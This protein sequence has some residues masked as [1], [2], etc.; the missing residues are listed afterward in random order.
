[1][2]QKKYGNGKGFLFVLPHLAGVLCFYFFPF[3]DVLRRSFVQASGGGFVGLANYRQVLT[4][5]AFLLAASN[6]AR[7]DIV[8]LPLLL[9][10]ALLIAVLLNGIKKMAGVFSSIFLIPMTIPAASIVFLWKVVFDSHGLLNGVL[11]AMEI[12]GREWLSGADSFY[13][14]VF[15]YIWKNLGYVVV[16]FT[17]V[18]DGIP[19]EIYEAAKMDGADGKACFVY[20]TLP[21]I[22]KGVFAIFVLSF[23]GTFR[24]FREAYLVAGS[25]PPQQIYMLQHVFNNWF[26][27]LSMDKLAAGAVLLAVVLS[28]LLLFMN[29]GL[30]GDEGENGKA[31]HGRSADGGARDEK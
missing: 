3:A 26:V 24:V 4:N 20:M 18:L 8:C 16:L 2:R 30:A 21:L 13:V 23:L 6:T 22:R 27:N 11:H 15:S 12:G 31:K 19:A 7:F 5:R 28:I 14:L 1:M 10:L 9:G 17:A 25:Y 29:R